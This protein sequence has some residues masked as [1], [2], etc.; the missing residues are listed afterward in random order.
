MP[1]SHH[2]SCIDEKCP[3][4]VVCR[5]LPSWT[6]HSKSAP[7]EDAQKR[8]RIEYERDMRKKK[9]EAD[10][11]ATELNTKRDAGAENMQA[12]DAMLKRLCRRAQRDIPGR[13]VAQAP[14]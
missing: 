5:V 14:S 13:S 10:A 9:R 1:T 8:K 12:S 2:E 6:D 7:E 11:E 3:S 4:G